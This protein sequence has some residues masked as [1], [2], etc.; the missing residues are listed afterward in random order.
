MT[1]AC[2]VHPELGVGWWDGN[3]PMTITGMYWLDGDE[4]AHKLVDRLWYRPTYY[5]LLRSA[6][7]DY[8]KGVHNGKA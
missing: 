8:S 2:K 7:Y 5:D 3:M 1:I 4:V 6:K